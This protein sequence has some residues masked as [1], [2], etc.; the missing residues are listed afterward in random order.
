MWSSRFSSHDDPD[1]ELIRRMSAPENEI[2][3]AVPLNVVVARTDEVAVALLGLQ[4]FT[5]GLSFDLALRK[6]SGRN[7]R[8]LNEVLFD[9]GPHR[10][11]GLMLGIELADGRRQSNVP[12][13]GA[14]HDP[15]PRSDTDIVFHSGGGGG[16]DRAV[17]Q[18]WWLSP[19]PPE[20]P[21]TLVVRCDALG[22][23]ETTT[24]IDATPIS[25]AAAGVVTL[26]P[27]TPPDQGEYEPPPPPDLPPGSWFAG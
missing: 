18:S 25:R 2:P 24:V 22:I 15:W 27:W 16:G 23:G 20:G 8:E 14:G 19:L 10:P 13:P 12:G 4:V 5:T 11:G 7:G 21:L 9:H 3:V 6:R 1:P 26:W 17:D